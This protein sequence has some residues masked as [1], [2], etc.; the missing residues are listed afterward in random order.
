MMGLGLDKDAALLV[1]TASWERD[2][3]SSSPSMEHGATR[4]ASSA[5]VGE[6]VTRLLASEESKNG[7]LSDCQIMG[8]VIQLHYV[9]LWFSCDD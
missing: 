8:E 1:P 6:I 2:L 4:S 7:L 3:P 9:R 5:D